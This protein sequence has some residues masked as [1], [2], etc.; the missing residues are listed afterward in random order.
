M[1]GSHCQITC[2][3]PV[4]ENTEHEIEQFLSIPDIIGDP[5]IALGRCCD[6][7]NIETL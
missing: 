4:L 5:T 6:R 1:L 7:A 3:I 2:L